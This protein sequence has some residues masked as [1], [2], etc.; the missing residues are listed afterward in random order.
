MIELIHPIIECP[1]NKRGITPLMSC[2]KCPN[3]K[4]YNMEYGVLCGVHDNNK[5]QKT[6][7]KHGDK[8]W[9]CDHLHIEHIEYNKYQCIDCGLQMISR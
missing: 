1:L 8:F 9:H 6:L 7:S 2:K 3:H 5:G 4:G